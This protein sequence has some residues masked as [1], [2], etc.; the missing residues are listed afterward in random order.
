M[1]APREYGRFCKIEKFL[2][3]EF[4]RKMSIDNVNKMKGT[5]YSPLSYK[6]FFKS[7]IPSGCRR[8]SLRRF[9]FVVTCELP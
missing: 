1:N 3:R 4:L 2:L 5:N 6:E 7:Q 9:L 8:S